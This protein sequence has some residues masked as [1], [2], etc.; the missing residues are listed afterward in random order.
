MRQILHSY[1]LRLTNLSQGNRALKLTRLSGRRDIDLHDLGFLHTKGAEEFLRQIIAQKDVRLL[2]RLDPRH[3]ATNVVDRRLNRIFRTARTLLEES[4]SYDLFVGYPF[5][6]GKFLD[7]TG[8]R[9]PVLL[10]PVRLIRDLQSRPRW[11]LEA[12]KEE[13][14]LFNKTFFLAYERYQ[15][16]RLPAEFWE[17]EIE[18]GKDWRNWL[19]ELYE[20]IKRYELDLNFNPRL[21]DLKLENY[22]DFQ[23]S[24]F[25][26][27]GLGNLTFRSQAVLG[28]FPQSDSALL[29]DYIHLSQQADD[30]PIDQLFPDENGRAMPLADTKKPA[31]IREEDRYFVTPVDQSQEDALIQVKQGRSL[32]LHGPPGTG[33]SQVIVNLIADAMAHGKKVLL[34]SQKRAALDVVHKRL[35]ALG[36]SRFSMLVH[37][38]RHD[39]AA[40]FRMLKRQIDDIDR[41]KKDI[42][43]L[44]L[45]QWEHAY[46]HLSRDVDRLTQ[47]F[48]DLH[49]GLR[50]TQQFGLSVH[51]LYLRSDPEQDRFALNELARHLDHQGLE[52]FLE[53]IAALN[54]FAELWAEAHPWRNRRSFRHFGYDDRD[55]IMKVLEAIPKQIQQL[56]ET[57]SALSKSL[58]TRILDNTL[59]VE[60]IQAFRALNQKV[61]DHQ[62]REAMENI[63]LGFKRP[64]EV[65]IQLEKVEEMLD[66]LEEGRHWLSDAHWQHCDTLWGHIENYRKKQNQTF[67]FLS[68]SW[69]RS[70]KYLQKLLS[71]HQIELDESSLKKLRKEMQLYRKLQKWYGKFYDK[72]FLG[73]FPLV[74]AQNE[75]RKWLEKK[76]EQYAAWQSVQEITYFRKIKPS[77]GK[78]GFDMGKWQHSMKEIDGLEAFSRQ[79]QD[80]RRNWGTWLHPEQFAELDEYV[81]DPQSGTAHWEALTKSFREDAADLQQLDQ[82]L[83]DLSPAE[84]QALEVIRP[85]LSANAD[86]KSLLQKVRNSVY[87]YWI[88]QVERRIPILAEVS[89]RSWPRRRKDFSQKLIDS[90]QKVAELVQRRIKE[91]IIGIIEYNRLSNPITYRKIYHQVSKKR[92]LWSVRKLIAESWDNGLSQ[93]A[94]CWMASPESVAALFPMQAGFFDLVIFDEA[95]QC[96]VEKGVPVILRGKQSVIA[97][98]HQQLQPLDLYTVKYDEA[99]EAFAENEL[100]LEVESILDLARAVYPETRLNWHYRS[101]EDPL[102]NYS[103]QAFYDGQLQV[104]P[105]A[106]HNQDFQP[107]LKWV[108]VPGIWQRNRNQ[109]EADRIVRIVEE[110][111]QRPNPPSIGI[112]TFNFHQQELIKD[113]L[114][115]RLE[116]LATHDKKTYEALLGAMQKTEAEEFMGLFVKNIENVQGDERDVI[117]FSIGYAPDLKGKLRTNFGLLNQKGGENRLN[118]AISRAR[119]QVIVVCSF[120]PEDLQVEDAAND[121]PRHFKRYLQYVKAVSDDNFALARRMIKA[122][123]SQTTNQSDNPIAEI[124]AE[125]IMAAGFYVEKNL[126]NTAYQLD[127]AVKAR[128][129]D[130]YYLLGI[131]CEGPNYFSG[132]SSK[133]REVYRSD[134]LR[135]KGWEVL[136]VWGRTFWRQP[137]KE[138]AR[139]LRRCEERVER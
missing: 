21:F 123:D 117:I 48:A 87:C 79:L 61:Q 32:V 124:L 4:G 41:F 42:N 63:R 138:I 82:I 111:V 6:E 108:S 25:D 9:C 17:E 20:T 89:S 24:V 35:G 65:G 113:G 29:Q 102:I 62:M 129:E 69:H 77:F 112:V 45:T 90:R 11:V 126:G 100:A 53:R 50:D 16:T 56:H 104:I 22:P 118:V 96:F 8:V 75:K 15:Q 68:R 95:S 101:Q 99:E 72:V 57:Y 59:N 74:S 128:A 73:D 28:L 67:R 137:E 91:R 34:V 130:D 98:D 93:L 106:Q 131:E 125:K 136:R 121:G 51:E 81:K 127:L 58:S 110:L 116:Y 92:R 115:E 39:R 88:E 27:F 37:D 26:S 94:P 66:K 76:E 109:Q 71:L 5:V 33:K 2:D 54:D 40:I 132:S 135:D 60:R 43:D 86:E 97:G 10:F 139:V 55:K 84:V 49:K 36:L 31:Y 134:L 30:F 83:A 14:I 107:P 3:E 38:V 13:P 85:E 12:L 122:Q 46:K 18:A 114:D 1:Q 44:N 119:E 120:R 64:A 103:N 52:R 105:P 19:T 47:D 78:G 7:G 133:E 23:A 80:L 70:K